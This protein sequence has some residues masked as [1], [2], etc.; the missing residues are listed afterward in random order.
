MFRKALCPVCQE[1]SRNIESDG[2]HRLPGS[3][4][5]KPVCSDRTCRNF[6]EWWAQAISA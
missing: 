3:E 4:A 5:T 2:R 1:E 6:S